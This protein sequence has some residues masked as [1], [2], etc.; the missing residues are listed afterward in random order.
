MNVNNCL[1]I[2]Y[3]NLYYNSND[4]YPKIFHELIL[5]DKYC[6]KNNLKFV[7]HNFYIIFM[8]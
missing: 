1:L 5:L 8:N 7:I 3:T 6:H 2:G 4:Y